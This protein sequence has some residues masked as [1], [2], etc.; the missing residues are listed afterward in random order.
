MSPGPESSGGYEWDDKKSAECWRTR[1]FD[2]AYAARVFESVSWER[3]STQEHDEQRFVTIGPVDD[4]MLTVVW[5]WRGTR[6]RIISARPASR[7]ERNGYRTFRQ[8]QAAP[9]PR[10]S[11]EAPPDD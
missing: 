2:F 9:R 3:P 6:R 1:G 11:G 10:G 4:Q 5:T 7:E 8:G